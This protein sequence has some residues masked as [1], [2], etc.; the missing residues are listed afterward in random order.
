MLL[1]S[2][3]ISLGMAPA[4][5]FACPAPHTPFLSAAGRCGRV[6]PRV[7][8]ILD[9]RHEHGGARDGV[10][11]LSAEP[12]PFPTEVLGGGGSSRAMPIE[13]PTDHTSKPYR[14]QDQ[15]VPTPME[16]RVEDCHA[17][18]SFKAPPAKSEVA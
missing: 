5:N 15:P 18:P 13:H 2:I 17:L 6:A 14:S 9:T 1:L 11:R 10:G 7:R 4:T 3:C 12:E 16:K 8:D